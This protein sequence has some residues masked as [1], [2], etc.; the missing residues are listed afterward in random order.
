MLNK[1][2]CVLQKASD[3]DYQNRLMR[4]HRANSERSE[5]LRK[6]YLM[7]G[8][9]SHGAV[10]VRLR[11]VV[12]A[13]YSHA[14]SGHILRSSGWR[15]R[16]HRRWGALAG[17]AHAVWRCSCKSCCRNHRGAYRIRGC[18][19]LSSFFKPQRFLFSRVS[20]AYALFWLSKA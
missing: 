6:F 7:H 3:N 8:V 12:T 5:K 16:H 9:V 13:V 17:T 19:F 14:V 11:A 2:E 10:V 18:V 15:R 4:K 20:H 1:C